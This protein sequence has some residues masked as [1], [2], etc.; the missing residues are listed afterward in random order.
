MELC[1]SRLSR[2]VRV[3]TSKRDAQKAGSQCHDAPCAFAA[4]IAHR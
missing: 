1:H 4:A 3:E 2:E